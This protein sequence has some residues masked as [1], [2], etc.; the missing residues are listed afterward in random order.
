MPWGKLLARLLG[1]LGLFVI[2]GMDSGLKH[3]AA[4]LWREVLLRGQS[5]GQL[6]ESRT[7][8][9]NALGWHTPLNP[10]KDSFLFYL[11]QANHC[12]AALSYAGEL[13]E[14]HGN[15][16][17]L[18]PANLVDL[19][20]QHPEY[21]SPKA[22]LRPIYQDFV[23]PTIA[24]VGGPGELE[25]HAQIAP[26]YAAFELP[27][28]SFFPRLTVTL[29][30]HKTLRNLE[31]LNLSAEY[32]LCTSPELLLK[33]LLQK[34]DEHHTTELFS[35]SRK[36]I[37]ELYLQL[38]QI[39]SQIDATLVGAIETSVGKSLQPLDQ[40]QQK[41]D[42]AL[43]QKH[44]I[45]LAR[46]TQVHAA[47]RPQGKPAERVLSTAY[48]LLKLGPQE[49]LRLLDELPIESKEHLIVSL[50]DKPVG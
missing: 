36:Q 27:A 40:L 23:L 43:K 13:R 42:K 38:K 22:A 37:E 26:F 29:A 5:V 45:Q 50:S 7:A 11:S 30:D 6:L 10:T 9:L 35:A 3:L 18:S 25:Y 2:E 4:P 19:I 17:T 12:R 21:I 15:R 48:Y 20:E 33:E 49:L 8:E 41:T 47:L 46:F 44:A 34:E 32:V 28:P 14:A 39:V 1:S 24:Y 16:T 31:K